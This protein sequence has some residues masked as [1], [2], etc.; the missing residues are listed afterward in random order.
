MDYGATFKKLRLE[1][2]ITLKEACQQGISSAQLSRFENGKSMLT[3]DHFF[4][5]LQNINVT[6]EEFQF[7]GKQ[8]FKDRF[9]K[10][11]EQM[12]EYLNTNQEESARSLAQRFF[13]ESQSPYDWPQFLGCF[14]EDVLNAG[15][16]RPFIHSQK[17]L[18]Y[19]QQVNNWGEM[20]LRLISIFTFAL[21][22]EQ[23]DLLLK[24]ILKKAK[25]Y[26]SVPQTNAL[27]YD[28]LENF[29]SKY[30]FHRNLPAARKI[31]KLYR[32]SLDECTILLRPRITY[33]FNQ[34]ILFYLEKQPEQGN[35]CFDQA[36]SL[37]RIFYQKET[38]HYFEKR[39][40][41]WRENYQDTNYRELTINL[42]FF[43]Y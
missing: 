7:V 29:F 30:V 24:S 22:T 19:L 40:K 37:A 15:N 25:L 23:M 3:V 17:V 1:K 28:L 38:E 16:N 12:Q 42:N 36:I 14:I 4:T 20:E 10:S 2:G 11:I 18:S 41:N 34:G 33:I 8:T 39:A 21:D 32:Q 26:Q 43:N 35:G 6:I 13:A 9:E 27:Y 31:Q 5:C